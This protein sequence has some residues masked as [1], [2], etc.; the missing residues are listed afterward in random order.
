MD[1]RY[2]H[3]YRWYSVGNIKAT[4]WVGSFK[5]TQESIVSNI[6]TMLLTKQVHKWVRGS[7]C[8]QLPTTK[9]T[10]Q[11]AVLAMLSRH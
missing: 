7:C 9:Y 2:V 6:S 5:W 1:N 4:S 11:H 8:T 10:I 3:V